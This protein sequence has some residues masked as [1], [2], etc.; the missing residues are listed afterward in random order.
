[1][2]LKLY[3]KNIYIMSKC[4]NSKCSNIV[5]VGL[6]CDKCIREITEYVLCMHQPPTFI[7]RL[8]DFIATKIDLLMIKIEYIYDKKK[9][10]K[11]IKRGEKS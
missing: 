3:L 9:V 7:Y 10:R 11:K 2:K 4:W 5:K 8:Y 6:W 1:M